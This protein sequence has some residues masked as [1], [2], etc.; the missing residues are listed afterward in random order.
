MS[1]LPMSTEQSSSKTHKRRSSGDL[2][3]KQLDQFA[4]LFDRIESQ[5]TEL[6][7]NPTWGDLE[8]VQELSTCTEA[9]FARVKSFKDIKTEDPKA[10]IVSLS[11]MDFNILKERLGVEDPVLVA[12]GHSPQDFLAGVQK[13]LRGYNSGPCDLKKIV[14]T[15]TAWD[16]STLLSLLKT[17]TK[18]VN[19]SLHSLLR[20]ITIHISVP[21]VTEVYILY[22]VPALS[23]TGPA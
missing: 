14:E 4:T 19:K 3:K 12:A 13:A 18:N 8:E 9:L 17:Y 22:L 11:S 10:V 5:V 6:R 20:Y 16:C 15:V 7:D 23:E 2:S 21:T 1:K